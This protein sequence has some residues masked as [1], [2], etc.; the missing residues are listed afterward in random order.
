MV[1][2]LMARGRAG[3]SSKYFRVCARILSCSPPFS[4]ARCPATY[5]HLPWVID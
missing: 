4:M 3:P 2:E 5:H 1:E